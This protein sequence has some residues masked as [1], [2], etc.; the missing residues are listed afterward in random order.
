VSWWYAPPTTP[1]EAATA[2]ATIAE[3]LAWAD[4]YHVRVGSW[5]SAYSGPIAE[6]PPGTNWKLVDN[7][8]RYGSRGLPGKSSLAQLL[9]EH[10]GHRNIMALPRLTVA[11]IL[12]W[13]DAWRRRTG[14]WPLIE[15]GPI[16][17]ATDGDTWKDIDTALR[18]GLRGLRPGRS[19]PPLLARRRGV[20]NLPG[21]PPLTVDPI[22]EWAD[23]HHRATGRW[24]RLDSGPVIGQP[25]ETWNAVQSALCIGARGLPG[26]SSLAQ[27][28]QEH[29]GV[30]NKSRLPGLTV[31]Q[32]LAWADAHHRRT[33]AGSIE[34]NSK[35]KGSNDGD[36]HEW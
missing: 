16:P 8:L 1:A 18:M 35:R 3:I 2:S 13:A 25:G 34:L 26:G 30:R 7:G 19:L 29:R 9:A 31:K 12:R 14:G 33:G 11:L 4:A 21:T 20:R 15:S 32:V 28:L 24:P 5:P 17:E 23:A 27:L 22:L 6:A 36:C 10:R